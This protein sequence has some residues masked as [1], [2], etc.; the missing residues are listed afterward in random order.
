MRPVK[1]HGHISGFLID[2][3]DFADQPASVNN[4]RINH[5]LS[6]AAMLCPEEYGDQA[7]TSQG[8]LPN[9]GANFVR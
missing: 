9:F 4:D 7:F 5:L 3:K 8:E 1:L 6:V 2:M